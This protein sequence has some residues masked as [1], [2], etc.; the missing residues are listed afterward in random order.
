MLWIVIT[1]F[2]WFLLALVGLIDKYILKEKL[3]NPTLYT[4]YAGILNIFVVFLMPFGFFIPKLF[5][6]LIALLAGILHILGIFLVYKAIEKFEVSRIIPALGALVPIFV[7]IFSCFFFKEQISL[8]FLE[9]ISFLLLL[10][11][12]VIIVWEKKPDFSFQALLL[13]ISSAIFFAIFTNLTKIVY[14]F[15]PFVNGIIWTR[16]GAFLTGCAFIFLKETRE[17]V[18][19]NRK[20][21][22]P[23]TLRV[24][25]PNQVLGITSFF[26]LSWAVAIVPFRYLAFINALEGTR[27]FFILFLATLISL[28]FPGFIK[29]DFSG[30]IIIQKIFAVSLIIIGLVVLSI[31]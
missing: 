22:R 11:G 21:L 10:T 19:K 28:K 27:Y 26:L 24:L 31:K 12:S 20:I 7:F 30:T 13:I 23:K 16:F 2:S 5:I 6:I 14:S 25:I 9:T 18:F 15:Q 1:I 17:E 4:F 3:I 29:E 8:S